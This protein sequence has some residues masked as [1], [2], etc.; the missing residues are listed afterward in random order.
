MIEGWSVIA[1]AFAYVGA[2]FAIAWIGDRKMS[3]AKGGQGRPA[4]YALSIA[5]YCTSWTFFGSVGLAAS[6]GYDFV[7]VYLGAIIAFVV[8]RPLIQRIVRL[9]KSQ[10]IT[11]VADFL[12]ARYGKSP[13]VAA[14]V[15]IIAVIG[16]LP[17]IALQLKAVAVSV[18]VL[19]GPGTLARVGLPGDT[20]FIIA[21]AMATFAVLFGTRHID[22]TEHQNGMM[23]AVAAESVIKLA[24]FLAVGLFITITVFGSFGGFLSAARSNTEFHALF[25]NGIN[26]Q[27]W[28][29]VT[30]LSFIAILLLPRQF[31]VTVVENNSPREIRRAAWLFPIYLVLI[32]IFV[33]PITAAGMML[34]PK[35]TPPDTFVLALPNAV[36][37][38]MMTI[39]AFIG[40]LSAATAMVIVDT[41]ALAIMVCNG[42]VVPLL[43]A[44]RL[45][46]RSGLG[47]EAGRTLFAGMVENL[48]A[49]RR[50]AIFVIVLLAY[51]FYWV[52][53]T[54]HGLASI[55]LVSFAAIAQLAP[56]FFL[57]LVWRNGTARGAIAGM[58]A[59]FSM[60]A[61]TLLVP[62]FVKAGLIGS[63]L[64]T[65]G[66]FG[67]S[68]LAPQSLFYMRLDPL[69]HGVLW[70]LAANIVCYVVVS[71]LKAPQPI[72]R[73][74]AN[75]FIEHNAPRPITAPAFRLWRSSVTAGDLQ[76][77][78]ARYLGAER[79]E[80]SFQ[81]YATSRDVEL[82]PGDEAD[83][84]LMRFTEHLLASAIGAPSSR[85]VLSLLL[86]RGNVGN[87][88]AL[89]LLDDASEALQYN[90]DLLQSALDQVRHGMSVF[91]RDLRL[92]CWNR[93]FRELFDVPA[94]FGRVGAPLDQILRAAA[95][96][97]DAGRD[98]PDTWVSDRLMKFAIRQETFYE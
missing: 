43:L 91:D 80:R 76:S 15:T 28:I 38:P 78:V 84:H 73:L 7:P 42:L 31:H 35:G 49:I 92:I 75:L 54:G 57:G 50:V 41:V 6:T 21:L 77:T 22:A 53:G 19:L 87:Q 93:Q 64:L 1:L 18:E 2:L 8:G 79:A 3:T 94:E 24:S 96:R 85:L 60:W 4:I 32:N 34:L 40:G 14:V 90:R 62:W 33:V 47:N 74:Q 16:T 30:I 37:A 88:A 98:D 66:P 52:I 45:D 10:N 82:A 61:Y 29:T 13:A 72:E 71:S 70:S 81:E 48:L 23:L 26:G 46:E 68:I 11:S 25:A 56:A 58:V 44:R 39:V 5:V 86:R 36:G 51:G 20:A 95:E 83:M 12:A 69:S 65:N 55:G 67:L 63:D 97:S 89:R 27:T 59:G 17:Y 9:A